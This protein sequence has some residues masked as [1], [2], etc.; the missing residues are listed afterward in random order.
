MRTFRSLLAVLCFALLVAMAIATSFAQTPS[1][2]TASAKVVELSPATDG[3]LGGP[4]GEVHR[5]CQRRVW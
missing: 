2:A 4:K 5:Y 3:H 1:S